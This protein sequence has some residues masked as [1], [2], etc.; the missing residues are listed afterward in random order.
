MR[1]IRTRPAGEGVAQN[2][3]EAIT[4]ATLSDPIDSC[5][6]PT[7]SLG[8]LSRNL[9]R[10]RPLE[11][12]I[13]EDYLMTDHRISGSAKNIGGQVEEGFGRLTGDEKT[14]LQGKAK[15]AEGH[16]ARRL[17]PGQGNCG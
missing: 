8:C 9:C 6:L 1:R 2:T 10:L 5:P 16:T 13:L 12:Q 7:N 17:R 14:Q 4:T 11:V 15:Q 3:V